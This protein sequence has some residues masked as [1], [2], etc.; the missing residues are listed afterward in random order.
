MYEVFIILVVP[1]LHL[2]AGNGAMPLN[3]RPKCPTCVIFFVLY[4]FRVVLN[5][6]Y[7]IFILRIV[8]TLY[9]LLY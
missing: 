1:F 5:R 6:I 7:F 4:E 9:D 8:C 3:L 2:N